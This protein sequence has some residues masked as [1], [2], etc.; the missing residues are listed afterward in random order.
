MSQPMTV[1]KS[2]TIKS[3]KFLFILNVIFMNN[4]YWDIFMGI[5]REVFEMK[6]AFFCTVMFIIFTGCQSPYTSVQG[7][8]GFRLRSEGMWNMTKHHASI[9]MDEEMNKCL[10]FSSWMQ[11]E[12]LIPHWS[13]QLL[14]TQIQRYSRHIIRPHIPCHSS[15]DFISQ[16]FGGLQP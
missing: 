8:E 12:W 3:V 11:R 14:S 2:P 10:Q 5:L 15:Q 9:I 13:I 7:C 4:N 6:K 1:G 16:S